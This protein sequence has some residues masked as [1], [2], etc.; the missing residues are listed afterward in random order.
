MTQI[1]IVQSLVRMTRTWNHLWGLWWRK[2]SVDARS[3][4]V[5][6][7]NLVFIDKSLPRSSSQHIYLHPR[8]LNFLSFAFRFEIAVNSHW[9]VFINQYLESNSMYSHFSN[10]LVLT[11][12]SGIYFQHWSVTQRP[13]RKQIFVRIH[14]LQS[15]NEDK[16]DGRKNMTSFRLLHSV[17]SLLFFHSQLSLFFNHNDWWL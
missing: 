8:T 9:L 13:T 5:L 17:I 10:F 16:T 14:R 7:L 2:L 15:R 12:C 4:W 1:S 3:F 6:F 11:L